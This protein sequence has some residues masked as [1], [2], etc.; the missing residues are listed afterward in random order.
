VINHLTALIII[1]L[2]KSYIFK[3]L[4]FMVLIKRVIFSIK[5][6]FFFLKSVLFCFVIIINNNNNNN[7]IHLC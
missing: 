7:N 1:N 4:F 2:K 3:A 6:T 5:S